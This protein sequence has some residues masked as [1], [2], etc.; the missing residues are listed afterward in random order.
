MKQLQYRVTTC[1]FSILIL[2]VLFILSSYAVSDFKILLSSFY[3]F[4]SLMF[5]ILLHISFI[6]K[7][8]NLQILEF[9]FFSFH[10]ELSKFQMHRKT[11]ETTHSIS[12]AFGPGTANQCTMQ[13]WFKKFCKGNNSLEDKER[14]GWSLEADNNQFESSHQS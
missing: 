1:I 14:S 6:L 3:F 7:N 4:T 5:S 12:N 8:L 2:F 13:W 9:S 11:V 10:L